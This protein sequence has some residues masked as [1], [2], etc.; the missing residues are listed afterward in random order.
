MKWNVLRN[1]VDSISYD[2]DQ[3]AFG[4]IL[5]T[6]LLFLL[7]T[8]MIYYLVFALLRLPILLVKTVLH[9]LVMVLNTFPVY[10]VLKR[11]I[12]QREEIGRCQYLN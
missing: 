5:F 8:T 6:V 9:C 4:T 2:A 1:R 7:P 3:L 11:L 10:D 12:Y